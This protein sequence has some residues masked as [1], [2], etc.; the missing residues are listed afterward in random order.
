M[1]KKYWDNMADRYDDEI[2]SSFHDDMNRVIEKEIKKH[3]DK[4]AVCCDF[5]CGIGHYSL[6][7]S[8]LFKRVESFDLSPQLIAE[9]KLRHASLTNVSFTAADLTKKTA[10][11][12][13]YRFA[14]CANVLIA[15]DYGIREKILKAVREAGGKNAEIVFILPSLESAL[16]VNYMMFEW[17][18]RDGMTHEKALKECLET[19]A[20]A[21][22][23][24]EN[25]II[26]IDNVRT[27]HYLKEEIQ[28]WFTYMG[29]TVKAVKKVEYRW[30][31]EFA[32]PD[33]WMKEPYPWDWMVTAQIK[34]RKK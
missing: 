5:G 12:P 22:C 8:S 19:V 30:Q 18:L 25:G 32:E 11:L 6:L 31:T 29:L 13:K 20:P 34:R 27:K 7:L 23:S 24:P 33:K 4:K 21:S 26:N 14:V 10:R 1:D 2:M 17:N 9:A 3:A 28:S 15:E 16:Y